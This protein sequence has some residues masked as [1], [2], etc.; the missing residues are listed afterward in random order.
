M[1]YRGDVFAPGHYYHVYNRGAGKSLLF[2]N[3]GNYEHCLRLVKQYSQTYRVAVIAYCLMPNHYHFLLRQETDEPL[4]R[5]INVLFNAYVQA[6]NRQQGR[7]GTLFEGRFRHVWV[8]REEYLV[9]LCRYIHLNPVAA[10]LVSQPGD[11]PYSNYLEWVG[12]RVGTLKDEAFIRERFPAPEA[13]RLFV[14]DRQDEVKTRS[15]I[16]RYGWD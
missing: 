14:A 9:Y 8:D 10:G 6:M 5:F 11:W 12:Q 3:P 15:R 13:Y 16:D 7:S 1:P 4:S 2:F